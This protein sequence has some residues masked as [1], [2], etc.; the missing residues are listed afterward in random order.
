MRLVPLLALLLGLAIPGASGQEKAPELPPYVPAYEPRSVDER[1]LWME[2]DEM[3]RALQQSPLIVRDE[4]LNAY[5]RDVL[6]RTVGHDRCGAVRIYIVETPLFNASMAPNGFMMVWTGLLLRVRSAAELGAV[7]G[8]E[9]AHFELRHG[10]KGFKNK[11]STTDV[12]MWVEVFGAVTET[13]VSGFQW[14]L[15]DLMFRYDRA[16]EREADRLGLAYLAQS[17]LPSAAAAEVWRNLM[18]EADATAFGRKQKIKHRYTAGFFDTHPTHLKRA[19]Y[20][21]K[22]AATVGDAGDDPDVERHFAALDGILPDLLR[23]QVKL[24][25]FG[26]TE[27]LLNG[28]AGIKG[29][30]APLLFARAEMHRMRG[31]PRDLVSAATFYRDAIAQGYA[32]AEAYRNLGFVLLRSGARSEAAGYLDEYLKLRPDAPDVAVV[33]SLIAE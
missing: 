31:L 13:D 10:V 27:Y 29:W 19:D 2:A 6:C 4:A 9:F 14:T 12:M 7:L 20:L 30:T 18:A 17:D 28:I 33:R 21:G 11:R 16:Q 1:G 23:N 24:N 15:L 5:V 22:E 25:D 8:H 26:G 3:E 32:D